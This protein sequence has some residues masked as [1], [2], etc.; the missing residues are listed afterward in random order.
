M[1]RSAQL[2]M[3]IPGVS[4]S[5]RSTRGLWADVWHRLIRKKRA[6]FGLAVIAFLTLVAALAPV[7]A[8]HEPLKLYKGRD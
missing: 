3:Q 4:T 5:S 8:P 6:V 2:K 7:L 1:A